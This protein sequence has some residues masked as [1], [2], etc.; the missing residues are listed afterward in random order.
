MSKCDTANFELTKRVRTS[1]AASAAT[2]ILQPRS[3]RRHDWTAAQHPS[4]IHVAACSPLVTRQ[5]LRA[6]THTP[7]HTARAAMKRETFISKATLQSN[8]L[9]PAARRARICCALTRLSRNKS[10]WR[11]ASQVDVFVCV[12]K[13][14]RRN[15]YQSR[16]DVTAAADCSSRLHALP[17]RT[18]M[19]GV[20]K[21]TFTL[22]ACL[23]VELTVLPCAIGARATRQHAAS[24]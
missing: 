8:V 23:R 16:R 3:H 18:Q 22:F 20:C 7:P 13:I 15:E 1:Q 9:S 11:T 12:A 14:R 6:L 17:Q 2:S 5:P 4:P 21:K 24:V 19:Q 10:S